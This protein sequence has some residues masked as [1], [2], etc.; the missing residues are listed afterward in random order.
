MS[1][2]E[3][4]ARA[5]EAMWA[6]DPASQAL[7]MSIV[8]IAPG[9][10]VLQMTVRPDMVNGHGIG[11]GGY[12]FLLADSAFA[13]ACNTT[14]RTTVAAG[15]EIAFRRPVRQGDVLVAEA[16]ERDG[17]AGEL[18]DPPARQRGDHR[19]ELDPRRRGR[20]ARLLAQL[21]LSP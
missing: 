7:D 5:A 4:A 21:G 17:L 2:E 18:V 20:D 12:T 1:P 16:V 15:A 8:E 11:H 9:R 19:A 14:G 6:G 13:F 3:I 10:A